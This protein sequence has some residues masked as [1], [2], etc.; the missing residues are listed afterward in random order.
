MMYI[1]PWKAAAI[2]LVSLAGVIYSLPNFFPKSALQGL[3]GWVPQKQ[4]PLG[5]DLQGGSHLLLQMNVDEL[6]RNWLETIEG[7]VRKELRGDGGGAVRQKRIAYTGLTIAGDAVRVTLR[8]PSELQEALQRLRTLAQPL[9][10]SIFTGTSNLDLEITTEGNST[11]VLRPTEQALSERVTSALAASIETIRRRVDALGTTEP[12]IQRQGKD[13]ILVQVPGF[14]DPEQLK[15]VI[16]TTA[17]L[18]F[19][20]VDQSMSVEEAIS[21]RPP[22]GSSVYQSQDE[23]EGPYLL[24]NEVIVGGEDLVDAQPGFDQ[25]TNEP[26]VS[27]RF[28]ASGGRRFGQVTAENVGRPFAIV[29]D[30][31]VISAPVIREPILGGSGQISGNFT[32]AQ[33]NELAIQL[34]SGALP[35]SLQIVE[36]RSVGPS[37]GADS[38]EAGETAAIIGF[39]AVALY[40]VVG[41][42]LFGLFSVVALVINIALIIAAL[43]M[44]QATLTL[45]GIAGIALTIGMA[46]DANVL[47]FERIREE[48]RSG[49][50]PVLAI[51]AGFARA[52]GT[53]FDSNITGLLAAI[54]LF[55]LGSG[56]VRGFAVTMSLGILASMFTALTLTR[57]IIIQWLRWARPTAVPI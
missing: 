18:T 25:Q 22:A 26:I 5:L 40:M 52:S 32:V 7:D 1:S 24:R 49:K 13:R 34:R 41:Y 31:K 19:Q 15:R 54:I 3:P 20:L 8:E 47:I 17:R 44:L 48:L 23:S 14:N 33:A 29:L 28:N 30:K 50:N 51:D 57:Y 21:S 12:V 45:P 2:I 39:V 43:S 56:P 11:I 27:F 36:E 53:I 10:S 9:S 4:M 55:W 35:A 42:G 6:R 46:V 37:L 38:I 16:N